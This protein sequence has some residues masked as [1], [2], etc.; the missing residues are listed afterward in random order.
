MTKNT[1]NKCYC[2]EKEATTKEHVPPKCF[3]PQRKHL[4]K[5]SPDYRQNL[6]TVPSCPEHN[7]SRSNDDQ[8][9]AI[10]IAMNSETDLAFALTK[11]K[12]LK[13]ML[14]NEASLGKRI[15]SK[16]KPARII[17]KKERI[18]IPPQTLAITYEIDR[19]ERVIKSIARAI[20]F[21]ESQERWLND[22][23]VISLNFLQSNLRP[24]YIQALQKIDQAFID[25][26]EHKKFGLQKKGS[27]HDI[28]YYQILNDL[29]N[30]N[31]NIIMV[32]YNSFVFIGTL[33]S[34]E[35]R[36]NIFL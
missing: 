16:A 2:C 19:I 8:Y 35:N 12:W 9:T 22:V 31:C 10:V 27:H 24:P 28:F 21:L 29:Q 26:Q 20:Y 1:E 3:F 23:H 7:N 32:F 36:L 4:P 5:N 33:K 13:T 6:I 34:K 25:L 11:S 30:K 18:L 17:S 14:R 15:F